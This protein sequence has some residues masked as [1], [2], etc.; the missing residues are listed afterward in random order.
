MAVETFLAWYAGI[1]T[2]LCAV[3]MIVYGVA[4]EIREHK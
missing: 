2:V 1:A 4:E 3:G